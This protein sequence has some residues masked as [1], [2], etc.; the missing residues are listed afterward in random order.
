MGSKWWGLLLMVGW[1]VWPKLLWAQT[2][3]DWPMVG[4]NPQ[5]TSWTPTEIQGKLTAAWYR[6][7]DPYIPAK[8]EIIAANDTLFIST[9]KGL[10][11][12]N[13]ADG[14]QKWIFP[15]E[16]PL[17]HSPTYAN[18]VI[19]VGGMDH[20]LY[21]I[22]A[23]SGAKLW[24]FDEAGAGYDTNPLVVNNLVYTG[25]RDGYMYAINVNTKA[26]AWK[27]KTDGPIHLSAAFKNNVIYFAS[28]DSYAYAL[29]ATTGALK[30]KTKLPRKMPQR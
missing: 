25:N 15:T 3:A 8:A 19:Y 9:A 26:L 30:W 12:L 18:G 5:R 21:A 13:A 17:G 22:D 20:K 4:A 27:Y 6:P 7:I 16:M 28:N 24:S 1:F 14:A 11:A 10:Y 23:F 29:D 2:T